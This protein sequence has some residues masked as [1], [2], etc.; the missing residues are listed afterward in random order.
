MVEEK[1]TAQLW[2]A[3]IFFI[4][5]RKR[6]GNMSTH[7]ILRNTWLIIC[8][9]LGFIWKCIH[10]TKDSE[11]EWQERGISFKCPNFICSHFMLQLPSGIVLGSS[12]PK[13]T[14]SIFPVPQNAQTSSCAEKKHV[15]LLIKPLWRCE[16]RWGQGASLSGLS[17]NLWLLRWLKAKIEQQM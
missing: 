1:K 10:Q 9:L 11:A 7:E 17:D 16:G 5:S 14:R 6:Q 8:S 3:R 15:C 2:F 13:T 12:D 4:W